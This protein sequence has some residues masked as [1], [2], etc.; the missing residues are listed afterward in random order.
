MHDHQSNPLH[1]ATRIY[2]P[3]AKTTSESSLF[4]IWATS[5]RYLFLLLM[6][7]ANFWD[8]E[9]AKSNVSFSKDTKTKLRWSHANYV[10]SHC[11][12]WRGNTVAYL[13]VD[14]TISP[15][16][17]HFWKHLPL[18]PMSKEPTQ[19]KNHRIVSLWDHYCVLFWHFSIHST[20]CRCLSS[21]LFLSIYF[22][23]NIHAIIEMRIHSV[24]H[25]SFS[26]FFLPK[27]SI[28]SPQKMFTF[29]LQIFYIILILHLRR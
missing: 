22:I 14:T 12:G 10:Q 17:Y 9:Y 29:Q 20:L 15:N 23:H 13:P 25:Y 28:W 6:Y 27:I 11:V 3:P 26:S 24:W 8:H 18:L 19:S 7:S 4:S 2:A 21:Y 1:R 5:Q 16:S